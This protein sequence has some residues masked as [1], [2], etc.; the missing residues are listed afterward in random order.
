VDRI[1]CSVHGVQHKTY[2]CQH[3]LN[4]LELRQRVGF[5]STPDDPNPNR[6]DAW[7]ADCRKR[8]MAA[9]GEWVGEALEHLGLRVLCGA[10]SDIA[11][12]F[13]TGGDPWA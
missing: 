12:Q 5:F 2:V 6:P 11:K 9:G 4:G 3:I 10:C 8:V 7:C 13:H 1:R